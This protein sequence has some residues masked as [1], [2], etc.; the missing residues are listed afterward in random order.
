M[1]FPRFRKS[2]HR[3]R[4]KM[5]FKNVNRGMSFTKAGTYTTGLVVVLGLLATSSG[6]NA[7]FIALGFGLSLLTISGLLSER[8]MKSFRFISIGAATAE[9]GSPFSVPLAVSNDAKTWFLFGVESLLTTEL[10]RFRLLNAKLNA[11]IEGR[12]LAIAPG[13]RREIA[14]RCSGLPRGKYDHFYVIQRTLFPFGLISKFKVSEA[15][16]NIKVLPILN[17]EIAERIARD[18]RAKLAGHV[19]EEDFHSHRVMHPRDSRRNM[20]WK[21]NAG[22]P[23]SQWVVRVY[24]ANGE[25]TQVVIRP[26]WK[27]WLSVLS[28]PELERALSDLRSAA[29][30]VL[31]AGLLPWVEMADGSVLVT[32]E[33]I[34]DFLTTAPLAVRGK[35]VGFQTASVLRVGPQGIV[36]EQ[37]A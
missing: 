33:S 19:Q 27:G 21:K 1:R 31:R 30:G 24:Q 3:L 23:R 4:S 14:A 22:K 9:A 7:F 34:V 35:P 26:D 28:G 20:D 2:S 10:P 29:E 16:A 6:S 32:W 37:A 12:L 17:A 25:S 15:E 5:Y 11:P 36:W 18:I 13:D 8:S